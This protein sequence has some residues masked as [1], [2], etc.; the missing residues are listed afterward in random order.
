M[1]TAAQTMAKTA[2]ETANL[3]KQLAASQAK[4]AAFERRE[5]AESLLMELARDPANA[6]MAPASVEDF[7]EKR[8]EIERMPSTDVA[9]SVVK[10][11]S[12][13]TFG[14][15]GDSMPSDVGPKPHGSDS[16]ADDLLNDF[17]YDS[18]STDA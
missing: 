8:A 10:L 9:R 18:N 12:Q 15:I 7:L 3:R 4:V 14:G 11:A 13:R 6:E 2:A 5:Q 1:T 17:L 16:K